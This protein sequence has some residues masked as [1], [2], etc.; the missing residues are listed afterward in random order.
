MQG[1]SSSALATSLYATMCDA[2]LGDL[3]AYK[4][5][6]HSERERG[7][8][9]EC[10]KKRG[11][12]GGMLR[13]A[14]RYRAR[15]KESVGDAVNEGAKCCGGKGW[16]KGGWGRDGEAC[17][18]VAGSGNRGRGEGRG[19]LRNDAVASALQM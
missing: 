14:E 12:E 9:R 4:N 10:V 8:E 13:K 1:S 11:G 19:S 15:E 18:E 5:C 6:M 16:T 3:V 7:I 2:H 17:R